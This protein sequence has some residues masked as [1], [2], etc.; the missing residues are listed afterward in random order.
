MVYDR[1]LTVRRNRHRLDLSIS[2]DDV[3]DKR[4]AGRARASCVFS[5]AAKGDFVDILSLSK[6]SRNSS[7]TGTAGPCAAVDTL[8]RDREATARKRR[9]QTGKCRANLSGCQCLI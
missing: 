8:D 3:E 4:I 2:L 5:I 1:C 6:G 9:R 7:G